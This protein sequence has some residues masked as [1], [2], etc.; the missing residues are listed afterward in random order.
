[1]SAE[2]VARGIKGGIVG[3]KGSAN[4]GAAAASGTGAGAAGVEDFLAFF[5]LGFF[6][7]K[8]LPAPPATQQHRQTASKAHCQS[9]K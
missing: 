6:P 2:L 1:M 8:T 3:N 4:N 5:F 9:C 7:F